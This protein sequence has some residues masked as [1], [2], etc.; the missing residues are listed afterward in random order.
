MTEP[1]GFTKAD[2]ELA[3]GARSY[4]RG[5][6]YLHAVADLEITATEIT[7]TVYGSSEYRVRLASSGGGISG[8]C[9]CPYGQ[10]GFFCKHCVAVGLSVL[11]IG[12]SLPERI[13]ASRVR[14]ETLESWLE[15]FSKEELLAELLAIL[16]DDRNLRQRFELRALSADADA[17][18]VRRAVM[19]L[20]VPSYDEY[21]G[22]DAYADDVDKAVA[23]IDELIKS[24]KAAEAADIAY[25]AIVWLIDS[26]EYVDESSGSVDDAVRELFAVHLRACQADRPDPARLGTDVAQLLLQEEYSYWPDLDEY[27][28]LLGTSGIAAVREHVADAYAECPS[29]WR[30]R[31]LMESILRDEGD[32][33]GI[34]AVHAANLDAYGRSHFFIARE[35]DGA[36]RAAEALGWAERGVREAAAPDH[37][38]VEYLAARYAAAGRH[39]ELLTLRRQRFQAERT[40][41]S[42]QALRRA[43]KDSG[44]WPAEREAALALLR[45]DLGDLSRRASWTWSGPVLVDALIDDGDVDA[46]WAA[47]EGVAPEQQRLRLADASITSRPGDALAVYLKAIDPLKAMTGDKT[48]RQMASL[49][50]S[51]RAC[52]QALGTMAEFTRYLTVLRMGQKRKRN[53]MKILDQN[54]LRPDLPRA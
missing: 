2:L 40:L 5:L 52:H 23:V 44:R 32:V 37:Q 7:A 3:A 4:E 14:R 49:L 19:K 43:A 27:R 53:L 54:G 13:E 11:E 9:T 15:S 35:L 25:D 41:A 12:D 30:A 24:G 26:L 8:A 47:A 29:S 33:D 28:D 42:Y 31:E 34:V 20:L 50:L 16:D 10:D 51:I 38:L 36:G 39:N 17:A 22:G 1:A 48:Y 21:I 45:Q 18:A 46:A 6:D